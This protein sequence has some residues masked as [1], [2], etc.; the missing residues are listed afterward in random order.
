[1]TLHAVMMPPAEP[2]P[3]FVP[4][5]HNCGVIPTPDFFSVTNPALWMLI[6]DVLLFIFI[7]TMYSRL[8]RRLPA[9]DG[10]AQL[11]PLSEIRVVVDAPAGAESHPG[12]DAGQTGRG[13]DSAREG[14]AVRVSVAVL[15]ARGASHEL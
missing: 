12:E 14:R 1:M 7:L 6:I 10:Q 9:A 13:H 5:L 2:D 11:S 4:A 8:Q 15:S 3:T